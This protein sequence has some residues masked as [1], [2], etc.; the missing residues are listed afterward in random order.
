[1]LINKRFSLAAVFFVLILLAIAVRLSMIPQL[2]DDMQYFLIPWFEHFEKFGV[3]GITTIDSNYNVPYLYLLWVSTNLPFSAIVS[4]KII[5]IV[6]EFIFAAL[7]YFIVKERYPNNK[8]YA[9]SAGI[10]SLFIPTLLL[11]GALW[12]QC[13]II[14]TTFLLGSWWQLSK[15]KQWS[16]WTLFGIAI[17]FK[18]QAIF[19]LPYI[20]YMWFSK[21]Q[22][23][24]PFR[25]RQNISVFSPFGSVLAIVVLSI[26]AILAGRTISSLVGIYMGQVSDPGNSVSFGSAVSIFQLLVD[27]SNAS[28]LYLSKP[29][30]LL[31]VAVLTTIIGAYMFSRFKSKYHDIYILPLLLLTIT[32]F[33]LPF[34]RSRYFFAA[35]IFAIIFALL[36]RNKWLIAFAILLQITVLPRYAL[37]LWDST[38]WPAQ[39]LAVIQLSIIIGMVYLLFSNPKV[40]QNNDYK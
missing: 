27:T 28:V 13:D 25:S 39:Y 17:A 4:I 5:T 1:M 11:Q 19:F 29:A 32:P 9:S 35:E 7:V 36:T 15:N 2:S 14:Y 24:R 8:M 33:L 10:A 21:N 40:K 37:Y 12:G 6:F 20:A 3:V 30:T 38:L 26:P 16:A 34:M 31:T 18:L 22:I 23:K